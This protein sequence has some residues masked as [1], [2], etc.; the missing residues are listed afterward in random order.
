MEKNSGRLLLGTLL[1]LTILGLACTHTPTQLTDGS[2]S[3]TVIG[4]L[5]GA[6]GSPAANT[7]VL[8][9]PADFDP[10]RDT[11]DSNLI[12]VTDSLGRYKV[13]VTEKGYYTLNAVDPVN[14]GRTLSDAVAVMG[15]NLELPTDTLKPTGSLVVTIPENLQMADY[16]IFVRGTDIF[17][18]LS[19]ATDSVCFDS[20]PAGLLARIYYDKLGGTPA[21][22]PLTDTVLITPADTLS[23]E[24]LLGWSVF[25]TANSPLAHDTIYD[26]A[27]GADGSWWFGLLLGGLMQVKDNAWSLLDT[28]NSS[29]PD[30]TV[31]SITPQGTSVWFGTGAGLASFDGAGWAVYDTS[32]SPLG[33]SQCYDFAIAPDGSMW[34]GTWQGVFHYDGTQWTQYT[35]AAGGLPQD[36]VYTVEFDAAGTLWAGMFGGGVAS[37]NGTSWTS[38][39]KADGGLPDD[40]VYSCAATPDGRIWVGTAKGVASFNGSAWSI[41]GAGHVVLALAVA[42][43]GTVW[44]GTTDGL[45]RIRQSGVTA[46]TTTYT[47]QTLGVVWSL[48]I[49]P[50]GVVWVGTT[51][52]VFRYGVLQR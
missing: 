20:L 42:G 23:V 8:L 40:F 41:Y 19:A 35:K 6:D 34:I 49:D 4:Q 9:V 14:G 37:F 52:G 31:Y 48:A 7:R 17:R 28:N 47:G 24:A 21:P 18:M 43:D 16:Y 11:L 27:F 33:K 44:A 5:I 32:N 26:I 12:A 3:E 25:S 39:R 51:H 1:L 36:S 38:Y 29:L 45:L 30:N 10:V 46:I 50:S 22:A 13:E 2:S 15:E